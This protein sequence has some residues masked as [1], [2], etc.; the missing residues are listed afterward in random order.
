M[1]SLT[2]P[3]LG[4]TYTRRQLVMMLVIFASYVAM[5][6]VGRILFTAPAVIQPAAGVALAGLVLGGLALWPAVLAATI[7]NGLLGTAPLLVMVGGIVGHTLHPVIGAWFL[8]SM[9]FDPVF[10]R[11]RDTLTFIFVALFSSMIVPTIGMLGIYLQNELVAAYQF[12]STWL[13]WWSGIMI[14]DLVLAIA[15]VRYCSKIDYSRTP[16]EIGELILAFMAIG[17]LSY[18]ISWTDLA[19]ASSGVLLLF[20]LLPFIWFSLRLGN[21]FTFLAFLLSTAILLTGVLYSGIPSDQATSTRIITTELFMATLAV[22]FFLFTAVVEERK[23]ANKALAAQ[24]LRVESLLEETKRQDRAKTDFISVFAHELRNPLAPI[25]TSIELLKLKHGAHPDIAP[26]I[27]TVQDR[28]RTIVRL[29]DD[30]L[31]VSRIE[32]QR[33][34]LRRAD[35]DLRESIRNVTNANQSLAQKHGLTLF[36][37]V[38]ES[39]VMVHA[40]P[41]RIEQ[42]IGN[43][44]MNA[45]K[46]TDSGGTISLSLETAGTDAILRVRDTGIGIA[47]EVL[48]RIFVPFAGLGVEHRQKSIKEGIGIGLWLTHNL[49]KIHGGTI[50][51]HSEGK[52]RG[53]EFTVRLPRLSQTPII[54]NEI[55]AMD[56]LQQS[57]TVRV[58]IVDDNEAAA[59]GLATLLR[60]VGNEVETA[61][62]G[63]DVADT[64]RTFNPAVIV[65]DIGLPDMTG[66]DV[67]EQLRTSG[68]KGR[69]IALTGYG[70]DEDKKKAEA[71][72]FD[73]H[74]TKPVGLADLQ[75]VLMP[76]TA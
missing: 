48:S 29:L 46:Y 67:A 4:I 31:D 21:R 12:R 23:R 38:P 71:A 65:L 13:S 44:L 40:D 16:R 11:V 39:A 15:I 45:I 49:A 42:M 6:Q 34:P 69:I 41:L 20:Y 19:K 33:F 3:F 64:V 27:E 37:S 51:V 7:M 68:F 36:L 28:T 57:Q 50:E 10:R 75:A 62:L 24:L 76:Q 59:N 9:G 5:A 72:G 32:R 47:P 30:L 56:S 8:R 17:G 55:P 58:L 22:I 54:P 43:L 25:V 60:H 26:I 1:N 52:G 63:A 66:Y 18:A 70:Q 73:H 61:Y 14:A 53:S 35:Y 2:I 74:L